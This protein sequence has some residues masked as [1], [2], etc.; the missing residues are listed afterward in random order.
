MQQITP[1]T[2]AEREKL[3]DV[4]RGFAILG[5][6]IANLHFMSMYNERELTGAYYSRYDD[7]MKFLQAMFIEGKFYSVF[8]LL[9]GWGIAMQ[10]QRLQQKGIDGIGLVKRRLWVML[11]LGFMHLI[12][13]WTGDIVAFYAMLGFLLLPFRK[14]SNK[15]LLI[16]AVAL[17]LSPIVLYALKMNILWLNAPAFIL[18]ETGN[19]VRHFFTPATVISDGPPHFIISTWIDLWKENLAGIFGRYGYLFFV[20]RISKVLGMF[21]VGYMLG[22][23]NYYKTILAN[24]SL[25]LKIALGGLIIGLPANYMLAQYMKDEGPYFNLQTDGLYYTIVYAL[26]VAP[27]AMCYAATIALLYQTGIKKLL[28]VLQP[29]GKMAFTNYIMH[30][31]IGVL[32]FQEIGLGLG[33]QFGPVAWTIFALCI[34]A[35][36]IILSHIW[37]HFF[38]YGPIEWLWRSMTYKKW[39]PMVKKKEL[40]TE[41]EL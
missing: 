15:K 36:Q 18:F 3:M 10:I 29:V 5:I 30:S 31:L 2:N 23:N 32:V 7:T 16:W 1:V 28:M 26:G 34:F 35:G 24:K 27:L 41:P 8:S 14:M 4:L 40:K 38:N 19:K 21:L 20:S 12:L 22:R 11:L 17:I 33:G 37:L 9:F 13:L 6:F 25:L 39:Q